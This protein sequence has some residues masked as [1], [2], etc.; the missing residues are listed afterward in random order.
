MVVKHYQVHP[1]LKEFV[2]RI[3]LIH[4]NLD[5]SQARPINPFPPQPEHCLYFYPYDQVICHNTA[6]QSTD[7]LPRSIIVGPQLSL[8]NLSMGYKTMVIYVGFLPGALP[9]LLRVPMETL[10][11][12][13]FDSA[14]FLSGQ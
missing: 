14:V 4:Y 5:P 11:D 2:S 8:V 7:P 13:S 3:L 9:R 6:N 10:C 12:R 1:A